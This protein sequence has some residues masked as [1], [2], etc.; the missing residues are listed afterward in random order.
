MSPSLPLCVDLDGTL[1]ATDCLW[2]SF[3]HRL[4][5]NPL[6]V[7]LAPIWLLR[8]KAYLKNQL[9]KG[10][11]LDVETLPENPRFLDWLAGEVKTGRDVYLVSASNQA[12]VSA[13]AEKFGFFKEAIGSHKGL[14]LR[15]KN[16]AQ[17]LV[18][19]FGDKGFDYAG[20]DFSDLIIWGS[21]RTAILVDPTARLLSKVSKENQVV[22]REDRVSIPKAFIQAIR[23]HQWMKNLL[24]FVPLMT[25]HVWDQPSAWI[26]AT[27][28][29]ISFSLCASAVY[30]IN[31]LTDLRSD[32]LNATKRNRP[33]ASGALPLYYGLIGSPFLLAFSLLVMVFGNYTSGL[34]VLG[35]YFLATCLYSLWL[36]QVAGLDIVFLA[37]LY[38]LRLIQGGVVVEVKISEWLLAFSLF[39]F[40][41]L[42][43]AKRFSELFNIKEEN[44]HSVVGRGY[45]ALDLNLIATLG[46]SSAYLSILVLAL[47][48]SSDRVR[49][50]YEH[51]QW[52]W[53]TCPIMLT[54]V[55]RLWLVTHRGEMDEDP[56][57]FAIKD[58]FSYGTIAMML[59]VG[60]LAG[61]I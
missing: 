9:A 58:A 38:T 29:F 4:N 3:A 1:L 44:R 14:N 17:Y 33:F 23:P 53:L 10:V 40:L 56:I 57:S 59:V 41:N 6:V 54:W 36:K 50:L 22:I 42:A 28:A 32:R 15:G 55:T 18:D 37:G 46:S 25:A 49:S 7:L 21:S 12:L 11:E 20:N 30:L 34:L 5:K 47:Y 2:E 8:G 35:I 61:P 19:R 24:I 43:L 31:D 16:K 39:F 26:S 60:I 52:I 48:V 13:V 45:R 27:L 51:P